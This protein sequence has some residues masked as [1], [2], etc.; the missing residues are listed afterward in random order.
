MK[1]NQLPCLGTKK[2]KDFFQFVTGLSRSFAKNK[3][4]VSKE[5]TRYA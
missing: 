2:V 5:E 1:I 3:T 4:I